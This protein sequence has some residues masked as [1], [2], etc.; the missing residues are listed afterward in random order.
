[1]EYGI[2]WIYPRR[3]AVCG[4]IV[5][6]ESRLV[7]PGCYPKAR[8][9]KEPACK[10]CGKAL[11]NEEQEYCFDCGKR[12]HTWFQRGF[13]L[14]PYSA[15]WQK[16]IAAY[17]YHHRREYAKFYSREFSDA[18]GEQIKELQPDALIPVPVHWTRY[19]Q[20]GY[21]QAE[22]LAEQI[23]RELGVHVVSDLLIRSRRTRA[24]KNLNSHERAQNLD[25]AFSISE[26]WKNCRGKLNRVMII[27]D[28][29]TTGSTVNV[30]AKT[31]RQAGIQEIYFGVLCAGEDR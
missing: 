17:K 9:I 4:D 2:N 7:C 28:I 22:V 31:L 20:R 6:P 5:T 1:M 19:I 27:D 10:C 13:A 8:R 30:C 18:F 26:K 12:E 25:G 3:C 14:W 24:Q 21:N 29:Y 23:G 11:H 16:S 15:E